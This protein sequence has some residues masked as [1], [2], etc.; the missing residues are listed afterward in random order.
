MQQILVQPHTVSEVAWS[1]VTDWPTHEPLLVYRIQISAFGPLE[2]YLHSL[3]RPD[4]V[5]RAKRYHQPRD[6]QRFIVARGVLRLLLSHHADQ[7]AIDLEFMTDHTKKPFLKGFPHLHYNVSHAGDWIV[8]AVAAN[9]V[10]VDVEKMEPEFDFQAVMEHVFSRE[11][12]RVIEQSPDARLRFYELWTRKEALA[13]ATAKGIDDDFHRLPALEGTHPVPDG[14]LTS[15]ESWTVRSF[16]VAD[17]H[18]GAVA[19]TKISGGPQP[20]FY[21]VNDS[22]FR[23]PY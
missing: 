3:L 13:K 10:G 17:A 23:V 15:T 22:L 6:R 21:T 9:R 8:I 11:E 16:D 1:S 18:M 4:E 7:S 5:L 14:L 2:S 19:Y 20:V 12:R